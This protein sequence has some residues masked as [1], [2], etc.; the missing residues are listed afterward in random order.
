VKKRGALRPYAIAKAPVL[1]FDTYVPDAGSYA[2]EAVRYWTFGGVVRT[3]HRKVDGMKGGQ[4]LKPLSAWREVN[5]EKIRTAIE[6]MREGA[7]ISMP[8]GYAD[9][10]RARFHAPNVS[11]SHQVHF[12]PYFRGAWQEALVTGVH[13]GAWKLYD[14]RQAYLWAA[15]Q[16]LPDPRSYHQTRS[17]AYARDAVYLARIHPQ[18]GLPYPY[19]TES[20]VLVS[21]EDIKRY[22]LP[23][24]E[25]LCGVSWRR[26]FNVQKI[27]DAIDHWT[28]RKEVARAYWGAW[29]P[30]ARVE[31]VTPARR[32]ELP[33]MGS[34]IIWA[35]L[36]VARV[37][38][39]LAEVARGACHVFVDSVLT[40]DTLTT[41]DAV[42]DWRLVKE[43]ADGVKVGGPGAYGP[44]AGDWDRYA[45]VPR[46]ARVPHRGPDARHVGHGAGRLVLAEG[47]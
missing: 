25:I 27:A 16:G 47:C 35:H 42:G 11:W 31:C 17:T 41:G 38:A 30:S 15:M 19:A 43:Y 22:D 24:E 34:N 23:V 5:E 32:W 3:V 1:G 12:T 33:P 40:Q 20:T 26:S 45:G 13:F 9:A 28:F 29:A 21:G 8:T 2:R 14:L 37:R 39:R 36:I 7:G 6:E 10:F 4:Y 46:A 44:R 18:P